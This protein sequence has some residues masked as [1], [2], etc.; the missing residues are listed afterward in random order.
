MNRIAKF[1]LA[2][3]SPFFPLI[4][5]CQTTTPESLTVEV[6][7]VE[8]PQDAALSK[9]V[10]SRLLA[11]KKANLSGVN[12]ASSGGTVYLSGIVKSLDARQQAIKLAWEVR[13]VQSVVN[14]LEVEK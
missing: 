9:S 12:V 10:R 13:G 2:A 6:P 4:H 1:L 3:S 5:A 11:D 7:G 14:R 8:S